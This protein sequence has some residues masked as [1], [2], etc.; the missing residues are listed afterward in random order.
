[1]AEKIL[2]EVEPRSDV[3][4]GAC[5]RM[6]AA[7]KVP[8]VVY[9]LDR[10]PFVI[11][12]SPRRI[13]EVL[14]LDTGKNTIFTLSL[15]GEAGKKRAAMIREIQRDPVTEKMVHVDFV[16]V[17]LEKAIVVNVPIRLIGIPD[18]VKN[19]GGIL[20]FIHRQVQAE[21]LPTEIPEHFDVDV[22]G[23][24]INQHVSLGDP[25]AGDEEKVKVL[26][27]PETIVAVVAPPRVEAVAVEEEE[28]EAAPEEA[29]EEPEVIK[30][31]K[32]AE[33][34]EGTDAGGK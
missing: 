26:D 3:G 29:A 11:A 5:R 14:K 32:E 25:A 9:G 28:V 8:A 10:P 30:K 13:D 4:K 18:G 7:G 1:M 16:R 17:D 20:E 2:V 12:V 6:R 31:G 27:D 21:C 23:L 34:T 22:S 33:S 19:E 15:A 24:H